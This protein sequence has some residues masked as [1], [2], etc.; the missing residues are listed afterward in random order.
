MNK[1]ETQSNKICERLCVKITASLDAPLLIGSGE[2]EHTDAD[3]VVNEQ[4][5]PYIPGSAL[6]GAMRRYM[7]G[8]DDDEIPVGMGKKMTPADWLFGAPKNGEAGEV[9]DR[10]SRIFVYDAQL[11]DDA[12]IQIRD[13]V[14][15]DENKTAVAM[16]KYEMEIVERGASLV[17]RF[18]IIEREEWLEI[19]ESKEKIQEKNMAWIQWLLHGF[20]SGE[21]R[22][23]GRNNRGFGKIAIKDVYVKVFDMSKAYQT[24]LNWDWNQP[25]AFQGAQR[26]EIV[27]KNQLEHCLEIPLSIPDTLLVRSYKTSFS[28]ENGQADYVQLTVGGEG[29]Q[30]VIPGSSWAGAFRSHLV[31]IIREMGADSGFEKTQKM[32]EPLFGSWIS[33]EEKEQDLKPSRLVFE[34]TLVEGGHGLPTARNAIDRFTGGTVQGALYEEIPW[35]QGAGLLRIRWR[36]DRISDEKELTEAAICGVLLWAIKDLQAGFLAVGGETAV[37]RGICMEPKIPLSIKFDGQELKEK[38]QEEYMQEAAQWI[39]DIKK[40]NARRNAN[41]RM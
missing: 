4:G 1:T 18:E 15:L 11:L 35:V 33:G 29:K 12:K 24:W 9:D 37:G 6:A 22:L 8:I 16:G 7:C 21:L 5:Q 32:L 10:Q 38:R 26:V 36:K 34:E 30:A 28:R 23:G 2:E 25:D 13:G 14:K 3:V 41:G 17:L 27:N 40:Q 31:K 19:F 20:D 39:Q